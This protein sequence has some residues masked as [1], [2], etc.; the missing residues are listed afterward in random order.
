MVLLHFQLPGSQRAKLCTI[1]KPVGTMPA[2]YPNYAV[3]TP[4]RDPNPRRH[5]IAF[6]DHDFEWTGLV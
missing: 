5:E 3:A 6:R 2:L 4:G 1:P